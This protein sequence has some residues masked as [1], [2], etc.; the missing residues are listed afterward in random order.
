MRNVK[1]SIAISNEI[2]GDGAPV[3]LQG[4]VEASLKTASELGFDAVEYHLRDPETVDAQALKALCA[5]YGMR[6]SALGTGLEYS[7]NGNSF[8]SPKAAVRKRTVE[9]FRAF[10]DLA[11]NF[12]ACVFL[13]L[14]RGTAPSF[15]EREKYL[16]LFVSGIQPLLGY[17]KEKNVV[18]ALEPI[19][20]YMTNLLNKTVETLDFIAL[21]N[22]EGVRLL[23]DTHHMYI[24]DPSIEEAFR[25]SAGMTAHIHI[26]D[27]D[28]R[29]PGSGRVDYA[30]VG[31][32]LS[33]TGY[34][35]AVSVEILPYPSA[36]QAARYSIQ[37][38]KSVWA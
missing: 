25:L 33:A 12:G 16:D 11:S 20:F 3:P 24:E 6:I 19:A 1:Y 28:R 23:L 31:R 10:I 34:A 14:C 21:R 5:K 38:M 18:L 26:S 22:L 37:W 7:L 30:A 29:Y 32:V 9:K 17:A 36:V 15:A 2:L 13:G 4:D 8:T 35:G 27:S